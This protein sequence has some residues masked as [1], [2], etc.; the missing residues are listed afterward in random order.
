MKGDIDK[1]YGNGENWTEYEEKHGVAVGNRMVDYGWTNADVT[2]PREEWGAVEVGGY[3]VDGMKVEDAINQGIL[4]TENLTNEKKENIY[5]DLMTGYTNNKNMLSKKLDLLLGDPEI[6]NSILINQYHLAVNEMSKENRSYM[7]YTNTSSVDRKF[8]FVAT[9]NMLIAKGYDISNMK[10]NVNNR[11]GREIEVDFYG[12]LS[13]FCINCDINDANGI[14]DPFWTENGKQSTVNHPPKR[15]D[16]Y[17]SPDRIIRGI[18]QEQHT[19]NPSTY[20]EAYRNYIKETSLE[21]PE[22][23]EWF[24]KQ[25]FGFFPKKEDIDSFNKAMSLSQPN[26]SG[27]LTSANELNAMLNDLPLEGQNDLQSNISKQNS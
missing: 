23:Y 10:F 25:N 1:M 3:R 24:V 18:L 12:L 19:K 11:W 15:A 26:L 17:Y 7:Q 8:Q 13:Q 22:P 6:V 5:K 27:D 20:Y 4:T 9:V 14:P 2:K 16:G 21:N